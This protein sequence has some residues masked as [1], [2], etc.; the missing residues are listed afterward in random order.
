MFRNIIEAAVVS[1]N[2]SPF[3]DS[4]SISPHSLFYGC[5]APAREN[6]SFIENNDIL[7]KEKYFELTLYLNNTFRQ[8][9]SAYNKR[10]QR[11]LKEAENRNKRDD[12]QDKIVPG[13]VVVLR[14]RDQLRGGIYKTLPHYHGKMLV[15]KR[16]ASSVLMVPLS[17][18]AVD[19]YVNQIEP[20]KE[21]ETK[22]AI[23]ADISQLKLLNASVFIQDDKEFYPQWAIKRRSPRP[24]YINQHSGGYNLDDWNTQQGH[25]ELS[26]FKTFCVIREQVYQVLNQRECS[27]EPVLK[28]ILKYR[29]AGN[30][31]YSEQL[32][33]VVQAASRLYKSRTDKTVCFNSQTNVIEFPYM[34]DI[35]WG[36]T[37]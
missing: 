28:G 29:C 22:L 13:S 6:I 4:P 18:N 7:D 15:I 32:N 8:I 27:K 20:T 24:L 19:E 23:K 2:E 31:L 10:R 21:I 9:R 11:K 25:E 34:D 33:D 30:D 36:D 5:H 35:Y 17:S 3:Y 14:N 1:L 16:T 12:Y 26:T 37:D